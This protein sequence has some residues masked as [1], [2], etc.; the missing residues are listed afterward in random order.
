MLAKR[1]MIGAGQENGDTP[2]KYKY[3]YKRYLQKRI[4]IGA[5]QENG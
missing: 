1:I 4:M 2:V 5:G 3:K